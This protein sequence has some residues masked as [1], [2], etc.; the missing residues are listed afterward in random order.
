MFRLLRSGVTDLAIAGPTVSPCAVASSRCHPISI[1]GEAIQNAIDPACGM[2]PSSMDGRCLRGSR[3]QQTATVKV[4]IDSGNASLQ[5]ACGERFRREYW[6]NCRSAWRPG[7]GLYRGRNQCHAYVHDVC[8]GRTG[9]EQRID[10]LEEA[11]GVVNGQER[12]GV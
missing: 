12:L 1:C 3:I 2:H 6:W 5:L 10:L 8:T 7:A 11:I 4:H 9:Y